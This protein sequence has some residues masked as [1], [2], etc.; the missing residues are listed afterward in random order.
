[1]EKK[2]SKKALFNTWNIA[3]KYCLSTLSFERLQTFTFCYAMTPI[4]KELYGDN[5]EEKKAALKRHSSFYNTE[6]Q[7]GVII[8]GI[9][10]GMEEKRANGEKIDDDV[11]NGLK[12][13]LMGPLAGIGD[14]MIPGILIPI[15]LSIGMG[16]SASGSI[17][18][19]I[20]YILVYNTIIFAG[21][22]FLFNKGYKMGTNSVQVLVGE[23]ANRI[24]ES[25]AVLGVFVVG[26]V[27]ASYCNLSTKLQ[28]SYKAIAA[29]GVKEIVNTINVQSILDGIFPK[30]LTLLI[31]LFTY[32]LMDKKR[33]SPVK[34]MLILFIVCALGVVIGVF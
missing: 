25:F 24:K 21:S 28:Y 9:M 22:W 33:V 15:L 30:L 10:A 26:G 29:D 20:F 27:A 2:L 11:M 14:S 18:G 6:P 17:L 1:M 34:T 3:L 31:V 16:L 5:E 13:G 12:V 7:I 32:W 8:H 4:I 23:A 19:P